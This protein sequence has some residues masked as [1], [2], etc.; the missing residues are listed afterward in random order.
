MQV[1]RRNRQNLDHDITKKENHA[2]QATCDWQETPATFPPRVD[3]VEHPPKIK[4]EYI[5]QADK[6]VEEEVEAR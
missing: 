6:A 3:E 5:C 2:G 1:H 4:I